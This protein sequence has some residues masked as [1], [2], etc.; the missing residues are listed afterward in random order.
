MKSGIPL[1][2]SIAVDQVPD[3]GFDR[4]DV[5]GEIFR[6][7]LSLA[8]FVIDGHDQG[9]QLIPVQFMKN[10]VK[11]KFGD[12]QFLGIDLGGELPSGE[13]PSILEIIQIFQNL[14]FQLQIVIKT[15]GS[16]NPGGPFLERTHSVIQLS[17]FLNLSFATFPALL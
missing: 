9:I 10:S 5:K 17:P 4:F 16:D 6:I 14:R 7:K 12:E 11:V 15:A 1:I 8:R 2:Y 3:D 13:Q